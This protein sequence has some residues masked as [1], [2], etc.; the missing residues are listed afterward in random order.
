VQHGQP[1]LGISL[2]QRWS[3]QWE[4]SGMVQAATTHV[5]PLPFHGAH[6]FF[7]VRQ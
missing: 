2:R 7:I 4:P 6:T 3:A 1:P 5:R